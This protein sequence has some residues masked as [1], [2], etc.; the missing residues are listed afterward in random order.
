MAVIVDTGILYALA[1]VDD[2]W[3]ERA[4]TWIERQRDLLIV[5]VTVLPE[6]TY[7]L[8]TR[9]GSAIEL[10]F[11]E[12]VAAGELEIEA[13]RQPDLDRCRAVMKRYPEVG[14]V[15]ASIVAVAER[16]KAVAVATTDRRHFST[17]VP[18]HASRFELLP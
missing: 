18:K 2:D 17:V 10:A 7:L 4:R 6:V 8:H 12:S 9:L 14:F 1:D 15:D 16:L 3:H 5:P 11:A 13:L